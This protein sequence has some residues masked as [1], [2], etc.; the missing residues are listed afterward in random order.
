MSHD[1]RKVHSGIDADT[2]RAAQAYEGIEHVD[3]NEE[4]SIYALFWG[5]SILGDWER[6]RNGWIR[7]LLENPSE[8]DRMAVIDAKNHHDV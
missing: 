8:S 4:L 5:S 7:N 6:P 2:I 3:K 1:D